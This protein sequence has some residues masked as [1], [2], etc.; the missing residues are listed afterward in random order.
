MG[1]KN[2]L[3]Q[4]SSVGVK[5]RTARKLQEMRKPKLNRKRYEH[6]LETVDNLINRLIKFYEENH[7]DSP[8]RH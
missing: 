2:P 5:R 6:H 8:N 3:D 4:W 7:P 1:E